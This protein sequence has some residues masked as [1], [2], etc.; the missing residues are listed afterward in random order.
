[1]LFCK[2]PSRSFVKGAGKKPD[3]TNAKRKHSSQGTVDVAGVHLYNTVNAVRGA[4]FG[5]GV[6]VFPAY[7]PESTIGFRTSGIFPGISDA[8]MM[9]E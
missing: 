2:R 9:Y 7:L 1:M 3:N 6:P 4:R 8:S 5:T